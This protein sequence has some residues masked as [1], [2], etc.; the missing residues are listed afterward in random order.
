MVHQPPLLECGAGEPDALTP[1]PTNIGRANFSSATACSYESLRREYRS[2][3]V[4][5]PDGFATEDSPG[6]AS[7]LFQRGWNQ[8]WGPSRGIKPNET[9]RP[10][11]ERDQSLLTW[12]RASVAVRPMLAE[13]GMEPRAVGQSQ[14]EVQPACSGPDRR[15]SRR[16]RPLFDGRLK[17]QSG[18][19]ALGDPWRPAP[20]AG[21]QGASPVRRARGG[22]R[23][24]ACPK[25]RLEPSMAPGDAATRLSAADV[26]SFPAASGRDFRLALYDG[27]LMGHPVVGTRLAELTESLEDRGSLRR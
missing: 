18:R 13:A 5:C 16:P 6:P 8:S 24:A 10:T 7:R 14:P 3:D 26:L 1:P 2:V 4:H 12:S 23:R 19:E 9:Q 25:V 20:A 15:G 11:R 21:D 27:C 17:H 22:C